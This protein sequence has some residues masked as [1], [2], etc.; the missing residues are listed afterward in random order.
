MTCPAPQAPPPDIRASHGFSQPSA[1]GVRLCLMLGLALVLGRPAFAS[2]ETPAPAAPHNTKGQLATTLQDDALIEGPSAMGSF[3]LEPLN[4][5]EA[6]IAADDRSWSLRYSDFDM[7]FELHA[8]PDK[9]A[10]GNTTKA[11]QQMAW[12]V[13]RPNGAA[14]ARYGLAK[15]RLRLL[16]GQGGRQHETWLFDPTAVADQAAGMD[17]AGDYPV[18]HIARAYARL[19]VS[20]FTKGTQPLF[21]M[22]LLADDLPP[23]FQLIG[24]PTFH[25][26]AAGRVLNLDRNAV[27]KVEGSYASGTF[28]VVAP[29]QGLSVAAASGWI[30]LVSG[31]WSEAEGYRY[32]G[33]LPYGY[34]CNS[35]W[36]EFALPSYWTRLQSQGAGASGTNH[37]YTT[38]MLP[39]LALI[40]TQSADS[41]QLTG[42]TLLHQP[43]MQGSVPPSL[44]TPFAPETAWPQHVRA[45]QSNAAMDWVLLSPAAKQRRA[46]VP[47]QANPLDSSLLSSTVSGIPGAAGFSVPLCPGSENPIQAACAQRLA[48]QLLE[49]LG[50]DYRMQG[51]FP[52]ADGSMA[53]KAGEKASKGG[54]LLLHKTDA[55]AMPADRKYP[56]WELLLG[57]DTKADAA[58]SNGGK[59][60]ADGRFAQPP[61]LEVWVVPPGRR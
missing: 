32:T 18:I 41:S 56:L 14:L 11:D 7:A 37:I 15:D 26:D 5:E 29:D 54:W 16:S 13:S 47:P 3:R 45:L 61:I 52:M 34:T 25:P 22:A 28:A 46:L 19:L 12:K 10:D 30:A 17:A 43:F 38:P 4:A 20:S 23:A 33:P 36:S 55:D 21:S 6:E 50:E 48:E 44:L 59:A 31:V 53:A 24:L 57:P 2:G 58:P 60:A 27:R 51:Q 8:V 1:L 40:A 9:E 35:A 42:I 49:W 39:G